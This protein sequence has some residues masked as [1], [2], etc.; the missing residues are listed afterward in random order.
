MDENQF[1]AI[2]DRT[3]QKRTDHLGQPE[4]ELTGLAENLQTALGELSADDL[5]EFA[6][7]LVKT[8]TRAYRWDLWA[9]AAVVNRDVSEHALH[10]FT[11][12]LIGQG[13]TFFEAVLA[14]PPKACERIEL[15]MRVGGEGI[16]TAAE[17]AYEKKTGKPL[18][19]CGMSLPDEP[20][21]DMWEEEDLPNILPYVCEK[22]WVDL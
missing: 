4:T 5:V 20:A 15:G 21:G 17:E 9:V 2:I 16:L 3:R 13:K 11:G 7:C 14:D 8:R 1:W 6:R 10:E 22:Y 18:P 19:D 12:W